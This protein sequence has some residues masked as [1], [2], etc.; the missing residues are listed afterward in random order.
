MKIED[1]LREALQRAARSATPSSDAWE[2]I[3]R[4][5][6]DPV[7]VSA[8]RRLGVV[9]VAAAIAVGGIAVAIK[10]FD[11]HDASGPQ[12]SP[13]SSLPVGSVQTFDLA[14][15]PSESRYDIAAIAGY[16]WA[17]GYHSLTLVGPDCQLK[18]RAVQPLVLI[19][20]HVGNRVRARDR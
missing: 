5:R 20:R 1:D 12:N 11:R 18:A 19:L 4:R 8:Q 15:E 14:W 17:S 10:A 16:A 9:L 6:R 7:T 3:D 13:A 2:T